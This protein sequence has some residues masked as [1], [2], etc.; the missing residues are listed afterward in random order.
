MQQP[1][2]DTNAIKEK[3]ALLFSGCPA[4]SSGARGGLYFDVTEHQ[5]NCRLQRALMCSHI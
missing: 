3:S 1:D 4:A 2:I 5:L